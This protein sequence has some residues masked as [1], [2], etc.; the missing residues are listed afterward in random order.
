MSEEIQ[1]ADGKRIFLTHPAIKPYFRT[2]KA[3]CIQL[4]FQ[5]CFAASSHLEGA[6]KSNGKH[7]SHQEINKKATPSTPD[8]KCTHIHTAFNIP[9]RYV[10]RPAALDV[11]VRSSSDGGLSPLM[12]NLIWVDRGKCNSDGRLCDGKSERRVNQHVGRDDAT[13]L[14]RS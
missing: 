10:N 9:V 7:W 6:R 8:T 3:M 2:P 14:V 4:E 13:R 12:R 5:K 1:C 11:V